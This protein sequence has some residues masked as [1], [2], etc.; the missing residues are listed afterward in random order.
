MRFDADAW[1]H[2]VLEQL[3]QPE[4][5]GRV[6]L[7]LAKWGSTPDAILDR[8]LLDADVV[9][10]KAH[11]HDGTPVE[12]ADVVNLPSSWIPA[13]AIVGVL[14]GRSDR[15]TVYDHASSVAF[16]LGGRFDAVD[17]VD[18]LDS[19]QLRDVLEAAEG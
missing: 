10:Y 16:Y 7:V 13:E 19:R 1:E 4:R 18:L 6:A 2:L 8:A 9:F 5:L 15:L 3:G 14:A 11:P 12:R 17:F